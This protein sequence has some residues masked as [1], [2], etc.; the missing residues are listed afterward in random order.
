LCLF[1][2]AVSHLHDITFAHRTS[3]ATPSGKLP[4]TFPTGIRSEPVSN[5][6]NGVSG[7]ANRRIRRASLRFYALFPGIG[8]TGVRRPR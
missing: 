6:V 8:A 4:D 3:R 1:G 2:G 5:R 7:R